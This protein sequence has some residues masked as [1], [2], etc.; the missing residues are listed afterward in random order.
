LTAE[1]EEDS[2]VL[3]RAVSFSL[4]GLGVRLKRGGGGCVGLFLEA[5]LVKEYWRE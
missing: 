3:V 1:E 4:D 5:F 2:E